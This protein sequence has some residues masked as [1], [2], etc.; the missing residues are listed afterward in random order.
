VLMIQQPNTQVQSDF[1]NA[2]MQSIT[3]SRPK[4]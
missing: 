3:T 2:V 1:G 4:R